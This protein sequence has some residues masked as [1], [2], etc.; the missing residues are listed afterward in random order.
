MHGFSNDINQHDDIFVNILKG[1][2][3]AKWALAQGQLQELFSRKG[4]RKKTK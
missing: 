4:S 3:R 2:P 1:V